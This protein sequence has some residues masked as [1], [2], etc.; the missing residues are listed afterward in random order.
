MI[1]GILYALG[2]VALWSVTPVLVKIALGF[3]DPFTL[4]FLRIAQGLV[5]VLVVFKLRKGRLRSLFRYNKWL[6]IG[7][8]GVAI[9]YLLFILSLNY[10]TAGAGGLIVQI[11]FVALA[12]LAW[13]IIKEP[14]HLLKLGGMISVVI[15]VTLLFIQRY[16]LS[17]IVKSEYILGNCLM[18]AAGIAWG[19]FALSNKALAHKKRGDE[20]LIPVFTIA[21]IITLSI[22]AFGFE[23]R[24]P[25]TIG[26]LAAIAMLGIGVTGVG[27]L[28]LSKSLSLLNASLVGAITSLAPLFNILISH[29]A[30]D[31]PLSA[32]LLVS[33]GMIILGVLLI[34]R[35][36][37]KSKAPAAFVAG[38]L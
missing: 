28:L 5:V 36:E 18:I 16:D 10:T 34:A 1:S 33:A 11:Q 32:F 19:V 9:N 7:G 3:V 24:A 14:F 6:L 35:A 31:E 25:I 17:E 29:F 21:T 12:V 26:G 4:A 22:S 30:L 38:P 13:I 20:I 23:A 8:I 27:F 2:L 15:G 37:K